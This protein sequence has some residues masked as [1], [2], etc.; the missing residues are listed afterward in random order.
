MNKERQKY[1]LFRCLRY[2]C[3]TCLFVANS[4]LVHLTAYYAAQR[5]TVEVSEDVIRVIHIL[6]SAF[7]FHSFFHYFIVTDSQARKHYYDSAKTKIRFLVSEPDAFLS[8]G[9]I[10]V[11]FAFFPTAFGVTS[12]QGWL[13]IPV[14]LA[15]LLAAVLFLLI[16]FA[17][18]IEGLF[19]WRK[20]EE[21]QRKEKRKKNEILVLIKDCVGAFLAYPIMAYLLPIA[22]P[23]FRTLPK[24]AFVV[25]AV[26]LPILAGFAVFFFAFGYIRA[27][28]VR[29]NFLYKLK[30]AAKK[31]G[32]VV[33][34][35]K[36]PLSSLFFEHAGS[37]FDVLA[38]GKQYSCK[39]LAGIHYGNPMHFKDEGKGAIVYKLR[40]RAFLYGRHALGRIGWYN[41]DEFA[42]MET[43]F[44][45]Q[46][47][48][49]GKK[50]LLVCPTPHSIYAVGHG[51]NRLLDVGDDIHGYMLMTGTAFLNALE[52][53][54]I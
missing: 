32:Y 22:F 35:I 11:A 26:V 7:A 40:F 1:I 49:N 28:F 50:V 3:A 14:G 38:N 52:R 42:R 48:G 20:D 46:F 8:L 21:K 18:W 33:S 51:Q 24:T 45:Y 30:K 23:T 53:D 9:W 41:S 25:A 6:L 31:R 47:D 13:E 39:L 19:Y 15:G 17:T 36:H 16:L 43:E 34:E 12:L 37:S 27:F 54:A 5:I 44:T 29:A 10:A 4:Y 2:F